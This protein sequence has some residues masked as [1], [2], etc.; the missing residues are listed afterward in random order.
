M[1]ALCTVFFNYFEFE[2]DGSPIGL[3]CLKAAPLDSYAEHDHSP[4]ISL[5]GISEC[6]QAKARRTDAEPA[7]I[8]LCRSGVWIT[9]HPIRP[10]LDV[11]L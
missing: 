11:I 9:L 2:R 4:A 8:T 7:S 5:I 6:G 10:I 3:Q 1:I